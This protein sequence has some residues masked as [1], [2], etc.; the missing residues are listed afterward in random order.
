M[1]TYTNASQIKKGDIII[2][3]GVQWNVDS[4]EVST[5]DSLHTIGLSND[6]EFTE[7]YLL[8]ASPVLRV[9]VGSIDN[10]TQQHLSLADSAIA[11]VM[12][13]AARAGRY[14]EIQDKFRS[15]VAT[16]ESLGYTYNGEWTK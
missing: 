16:L 9:S 4:N 5:H 3:N 11:A 14:D 2:H 8:P 1:A 13:L 12:D 10:T 6:L 7:I 15:A